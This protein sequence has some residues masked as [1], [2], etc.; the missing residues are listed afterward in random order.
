MV[1][2]SSIGA[3]SGGGNFYVWNAPKGAP[4]NLVVKS[5][6]DATEAL[7]H[8]FTYLFQLSFVFSFCFLMAW[9]A[10]A[11]GAAAFLSSSLLS[12]SSL[13]AAAVAEAPRPPCVVDSSSAAAEAAAVR[14]ASSFGR[15]GIV[16]SSSVPSSSPPSS[17]AN[18]GR[19]VS[20][21]YVAFAAILG[22]L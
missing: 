14:V 4:R 21:R 7:R 15:G 10:F 1:G 11:G 17:L 5:D 3:I 9:R 2:R 22:G 8:F 16:T 12:A 20:L 18:P 6:N 19:G 13:S